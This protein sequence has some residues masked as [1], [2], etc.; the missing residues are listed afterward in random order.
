MLR[1]VAKG[2]G[3]IV[4]ILAW[5]LSS[6]RCSVRPY[7]VLVLITSVVDVAMPIMYGAVSRWPIVPLYVAADMVWLLP[8]AAHVQAAHGRPSGGVLAL[9]CSAAVPF[10][11]AADIHYAW[12]WPRHL[13][14]WF[15]LRAAVLKTIVTGYAGASVWL[16]SRARGRDNVGRSLVWVSAILCMIQMTAIGEGAVPMLLYRCGL[17]VY[18]FVAISALVMAIREEVIN[19]KRQ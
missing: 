11:V 3:A 16:L 4:T 5:F 15:S 7:A 8:Y 18:H 1:W 6:R 10:V 14:F 12:I 9:S 2:T 19:G 13:G 17:L